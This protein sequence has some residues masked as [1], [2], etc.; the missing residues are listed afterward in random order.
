MTNSRQTATPTI[1]IVEDDPNAAAIFA[2]ILESHGYAVHIASDAT[3]G[4][5]HISNDSPAAVL[6]DLHLPVNDGIDFLRRLR[7]CVACA[8]LPVAIVTGDYFIDED[9]ARAL[10]TL[11][12]RVHFKPLWEEDLLTLVTELLLK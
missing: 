4:L 1:L 2:Q 11:N 10:T 12:A 3:V 9:T 8:N 6:L 7:T 5:Q